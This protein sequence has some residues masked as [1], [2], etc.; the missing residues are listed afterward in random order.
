MELSAPAGSGME[1]ASSDAGAGR[2]TRTP[3]L[4][5]TKTISGVKALVLQRFRCCLVAGFRVI[6]RSGSTVSMRSLCV[7]GQVVGQNSNEHK[8][9]NHAGGI[10]HG[11][12]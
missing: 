3:D 5:I 2:R 10:G 11:D 1:R 8:T 6:S 9:S 4:L 12:P 7:V